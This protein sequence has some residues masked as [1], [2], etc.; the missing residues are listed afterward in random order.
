LNE[1]SVAH[2]FT[3]GNEERIGFESPIN[4]ASMMPSVSHPGVN[5]WAR[6]KFTMEVAD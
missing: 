4:G 1:F 5:A 2:A 3:P 6:E